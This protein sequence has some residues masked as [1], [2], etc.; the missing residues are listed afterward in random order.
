[1]LFIMVDME[2]E[3][4]AKKRLGIYYLP[5]WKGCSPEISEAIREFRERWKKYSRASRTFPIWRLIQEVIDPAVSA[6]LKTLPA[7][8][9][10]F[11]PGAGLGVDF[12]E[13][14]RLI[15]FETMYRVQ[16]NL[17]RQF[18]D[19]EHEQTPID[20]QFVA[21]FESLI[22][23]VDESGAK[24]PKITKAVNGLS[25]NAERRRRFCDFCGNLSEFSAFMRVAEEGKVND[26][27][28]EN[29]EKLELSH[30]YCDKH[31]P[32][33]HSGEWN[34]VYRQAKRS[35]LQFKTELARLIRQ[36]AHPTS[37]RAAKSDDP[38]VDAYYHRYLL[39]TG[40]Q[41]ADKSALRNL[42]RL[43]VDNKLS[44]SKK[45]MLVLLHSG[46]N[47][48]EIARKVQ[49]PGQEPI[50]RQAVSKALASISEVFDLRK[51]NRHLS[52]QKLCSQP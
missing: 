39:R 4:E 15:G 29:R 21:S 27:E 32:R 30:Q 9:S 11:V 47:Q 12:S 46:F 1:M 5:V 44:D 3:E 18:I 38:L 17:L 28:L 6:Y 31:R 16:R 34:H 43:I 19:T 7:R 49:D 40:L 13:L 2:S 33:F 45:K 25:L 23:L 35:E 22:V 8:Y 50:T 52:F 10:G 51:P 48:S 24:R 14:I 26:V 37:P 20:R 41:P 36:C 42:A